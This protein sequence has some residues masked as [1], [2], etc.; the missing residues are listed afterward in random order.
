MAQRRSGTGT[1][2]KSRRAPPAQA[3]RPGAGPPAASLTLDGK[4]PY[5]P[6]RPPRVL[7]GTWRNWQTRWI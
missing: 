1:N 6:E 2:A 3:T 7:A 4:V 5:T